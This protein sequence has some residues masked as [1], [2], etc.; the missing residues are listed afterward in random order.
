MYRIVL[1][2]IALWFTT[3]TSGTYFSSGMYLYAALWALVSL[4][5]GAGL[6]VAIMAHAKI[7]RMHG[8]LTS[9][10]F[11]D[12]LSKDIKEWDT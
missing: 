10:L 3:F 12:L 5:W 1:N 4:I 8:F 7:E 2:I 9:D 11:K 6:I